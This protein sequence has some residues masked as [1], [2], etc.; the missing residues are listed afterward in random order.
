MFSFL[1]PKTQLQAY[2]MKEISINDFEIFGIGQINPYCNSRFNNEKFITIV[3]FANGF[4]GFDEKE[5]MVLT[6]YFTVKKCPRCK[7]IELVPTK[8]KINLSPDAYN[9]DVDIVYGNY[10]DIKYNY[11]STVKAYCNSCNSCFEFNIKLK[12]TWVKQ[13]K[14]LKERDLITGYWEEYEL[15]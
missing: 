13:A 11:P 12:D 4:R 6:D 15:D 10:Q 9:D 2:R 7:R 8:I 5:G 3:N 14:K 1:L